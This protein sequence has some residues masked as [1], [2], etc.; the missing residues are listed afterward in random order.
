MSK[1]PLIFLRPSLGMSLEAAPLD[2]PPAGHRCRFVPKSFDQEHHGRFHRFYSR[3]Y[4]TSSGPRAPSST[5]L[6]G[7]TDNNWEADLLDTSCWRL[8]EGLRLAE[9]L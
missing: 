1:I 3:R 9:E 8:Q 7:G 2:T 4:M 5:G 6:S